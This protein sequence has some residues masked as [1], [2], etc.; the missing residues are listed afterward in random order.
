MIT[1]QIAS[2]AY[3]NIP[4]DADPSP[5]MSGITSKSPLLEPYSTC[6]PLNETTTNHDPE[7]LTL[8]NSVRIWGKSQMG[9]FG[10]RLWLDAP[11]Q[12]LKPI[13]D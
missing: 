8:I 3:G 4:L 5:K 9:R 13:C 11:Y 12:A 2:R 7:A 10:K 1:K 6:L